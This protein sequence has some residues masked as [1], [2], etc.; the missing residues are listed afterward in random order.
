[1]Q[2]YAPSCRHSIAWPLRPTLLSLA[3]LIMTGSSAPLQSQT[4]RQ[5]T[6]TLLRALTVPEGYT[7]SGGACAANGTGLLWSSYTHDLL[8]LK[9]DGLHRV[10][11]SVGLVGGGAILPGD[12]MAAIIDV[13]ARAVLKL[14]LRTG[15][16]D[17]APRPLLEAD[18]LAIDAALWTPAGWAVAGRSLV[19]DRYELRLPRMSSGAL[20]R[21]TIQ[22]EDSAP[23]YP[24]VALRLSAGP[25]GGII[26]TQL[27]PPFTS[28]V[29]DSTGRLAATLTPPATTVHEDS[30]PGALAPLWVGL[31]VQSVGAGFLQVLSDLRSDSRRLILFDRDGRY[32]RDAH[33]TA[34]FGVLCVM[35]HSARLLASRYTGTQEVAEYSWQWLA[36]P[37]RR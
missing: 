8:V 2:P 30:A 18:S 34:P 1:M 24:R 5:L 3:A 29:Y 32:L 10:P 14:D 33:L 20:S 6:L 12:T 35:P 15:L 9:R 26:A 4:A 16:V 28:M 22:S 19:A 36:P 27:V 7:V 17:G 25:A 31:P 13:Q 11:T 37:Q 21:H 23:G